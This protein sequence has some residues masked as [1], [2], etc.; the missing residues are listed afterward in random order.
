M[1]EAARQA[2]QDKRRGTSS[3]ALE[4]GPHAVDKHGDVQR[5]AVRERPEPA[6]RPDMDEAFR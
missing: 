2:K 6:E 3:V 1:G 5:S 4:R